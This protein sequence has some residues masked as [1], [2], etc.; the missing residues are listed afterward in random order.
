M[1]PV[2]CKPVAPESQFFKTGIFRRQLTVPNHFT[3]CI[4]YSKNTTDFLNSN[5]VGLLSKKSLLKSPSKFEDPIEVMHSDHNFFV[6][7]SLIVTHPSNFTCL[8][9]TVY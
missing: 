2:R 7:T 6:R 3:T 8:F 1:K 4:I 9:A 5:F